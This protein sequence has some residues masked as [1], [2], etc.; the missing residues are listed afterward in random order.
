RLQGRGIALVDV[1]VRPKV[2]MECMSSAESTMQVCRDGLQN[3]GLRIKRVDVDDP[4]RLV[5]ITRAS[6]YSFRERIIVEVRAL[7]PGSCEL[8]IS[9]RPWMQTVRVDGGVNYTNVFLLSKYVK[10]HLGEGRIVRETLA[11]LDD[12]AHEDRQ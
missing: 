3:I 6:F 4:L 7:G 2:M 1:P 5:V 11:D 8:E 9:S 12:P 10:E